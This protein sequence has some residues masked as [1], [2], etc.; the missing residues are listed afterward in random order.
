MSEEPTQ[1]VELKV[2]NPVKSFRPLR[3]I[4]ACIAEIN[5]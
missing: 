1:T 2:A 4:E 5:T 3:L